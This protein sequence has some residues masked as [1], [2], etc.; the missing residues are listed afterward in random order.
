MRR[1]SCTTGS[2]ASTARSGRSRPCSTCS[3]E[4]RTSSPSTPRASCFPSGCARHRARVASRAAPGSPAAR[5]RPGRWRWLLPYMPRYFEVSTCRGYELVRQLVA[6]LRR[7]C[8]ERA[9]TRCTSATATRPMRYVWMA[10]GR[11]EGGSAASRAL[12]LRAMRGRLREWDRRAA[13]R[14][15][16]YV[17]NSTAVA[18]RIAAL[19]RARRSGGAPAGGRRRLPA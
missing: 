6:R 3:R 17:A 8:A 14:P 13:R 4:T 15:D 16:V 2:R 18:E 7:G 11:G 9:R 12:A 19:L 5:P 1:R 10:D